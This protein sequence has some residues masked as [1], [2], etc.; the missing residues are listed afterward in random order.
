VPACLA[1]ACS[2]HAGASAVGVG[3]IEGKIYSY[4]ETG[5]AAASGH[6]ESGEAVAR[7]SADV[8]SGTLK[9][10]AS[11][12]AAD[13]LLGISSGASFSDTLSFAGA[14]VGSYVG[15]LTLH[16]HTSMT[17]DLLYE[18]SGTGV[19]A[20]TMITLKGGA[21]SPLIRLAASRCDALP[22]GCIE[23]TDLR[24]AL[25]VPLVVQ[26]VDSA[27]RGTAFISAQLQVTVAVGGV[28]DAEH[29][30]WAT[31][32]LKPEFARYDSES[33]LFL[34]A[35]PEPGSLLLLLS[36]LLMLPLV[37]RRPRPT[38]PG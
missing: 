24:G 28:A 26:S 34:S 16:W 7:S 11:G 10:F 25:T 19:S 14:S 5:S 23:G 32:A 1:F 37:A 21:A 4:S 8:A 12:D 13:S 18:G 2:A 22:E 36:G 38:P 35:V 27:G 15:D 30:A 31:L 6:L 17:P 9:A 29:T 20:V 33:G 3:Q